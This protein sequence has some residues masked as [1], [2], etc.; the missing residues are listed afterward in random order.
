MGWNDKPR[1]WRSKRQFQQLVVFIDRHNQRKTSAEVKGA[2]PILL[3]KI[4]HTSWASAPFNQ[5]LRAN[6]RQ[7]GSLVFFTFS[8]SR[9]P[10]HC[11]F[12]LDPVYAL[13][14]LQGRALAKKKQQKERKKRKKYSPARP[15]PRVIN[16]KF[17]LQPHQKCYITVWRTWLSIAYSDER[18][19]YYRF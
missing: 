4:W 7:C 10:I 6:D 8:L 13:T 2:W 3:P 17:P 9:S 18:C 15:F 12:S 11:F 14:C 1:K 16:F 5:R 19:L